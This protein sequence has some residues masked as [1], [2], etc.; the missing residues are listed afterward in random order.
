MRQTF[1][2]ATLIPQF[3]V[4]LCSR[5]LPASSIWVPAI[6]RGPLACTCV[7]GRCV[8][9][10]H[11]LE[12]ILNQGWPGVGTS[13]PQLPCLSIGIILMDTCC[14]ISDIKLQ[15]L[16][17]GLLNT[18][19]YDCI[20]CITC[21]YAPASVLCT[22]QISQLHRILV[23]GSTAGGTQ[24]GTSSCKTS[25]KASTSLPLSSPQ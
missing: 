8:E 13:I 21:L 6:S 25:L 16:S 15:P 10:D 9:T 18:F 5:Q 12:A 22:F 24:T 19:H 14:T 2:S 7:A 11:H 17:D 3:T 23:L 20:P 4:L 1:V